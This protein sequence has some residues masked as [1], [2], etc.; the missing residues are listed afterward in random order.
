MRPRSH[1]RS[2]STLR[3]EIPSVVVLA[4]D[5][6]EADQIVQALSRLNSG[7]LL[8]F[9][10][11]SELA[12]NIPTT[13]V[14]L[15]V[16]AANDSPECIRGVLKWTRRQWSECLSLVV[17]WHSGGPTELAARENGAL[18]FLRPVSSDSWN[19]VMMGVLRY[20][21]YKLSNA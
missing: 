3:G 10:H 4:E 15:V 2:G 1:Q 7:R 21:G 16:L 17:G 13:Q 14:D 12:T 6:G 19:A 18:F 5:T 9:S 20:Q 11:A 8:R